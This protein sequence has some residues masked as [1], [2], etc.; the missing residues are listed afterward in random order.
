MRVRFV[1]EAEADL[2]DAYQWYEARAGGLASE[3]LR[4]LDA[5]LAVV[6]RHPDAF[7]IVHR[8]LRRALLRRFPYGLYYLVDGE[9]LVVLA[10]LHAARDPR[11]WK[12]R[13]T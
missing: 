10:C 3:F 2:L 13:D 11:A 9:T 12:R 6:A 4:S 7:P 8:G 1:P 5:C